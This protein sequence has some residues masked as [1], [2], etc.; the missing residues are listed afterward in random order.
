VKT[1]GKRRRT[2][3]IVV[4]FRDGERVRQVVRRR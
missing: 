2:A 3:V 4:A 1:T